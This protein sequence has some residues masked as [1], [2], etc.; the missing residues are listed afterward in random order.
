[1]TVNVANVV[2]EAPTIFGRS[3]CAEVGVQ[4]WGC[5]GWGDAVFMGRLGTI[6]K[7]VVRDLG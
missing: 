7:E 3:L 4:T 6:L 2:P 5:S 1:M